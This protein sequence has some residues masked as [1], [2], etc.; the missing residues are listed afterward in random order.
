MAYFTDAVLNIADTAT[1]EGAAMLGKARE[2]SD[3][4]DVITSTRWPTSWDARDFMEFL[5]RMT[6]V[7]EVLIETGL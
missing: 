5:H 7:R 1:V 6:T 2:V 3:H 4:E